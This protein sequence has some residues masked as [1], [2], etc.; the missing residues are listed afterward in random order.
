MLGE[1]TLGFRKDAMRISDVMQQE[2]AALLGESLIKGAP[3]PYSAVTDPGVLVRTPTLVRAMHPVTLETLPGRDRAMA[4]VQVCPSLQYKF[5]WV[6]A[7]NDHYRE[8]YIKFLKSVQRVAEQ[9]PK[10]LH[11][12]HLY[13][14]ERARKLNTPYIRIVLAPAGVNCSHGAGW[15]KS[16]TKSGLGRSGRDHTM[17]E[18][19]LMKLCGVPSPRKAQTLTA[20]VMAHIHHVAQLYGVT[21]AEVEGNIQDLMSAAAYKPT[22]NTMELAS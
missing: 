16:R 14:R 13:N 17:D 8:D 9:L 18:L 11:A 4:F 10:D 2:R 21:V 12:D 20:E 7:D 22:T 15:E 1:S 19:T 6:H 5:L 3:L